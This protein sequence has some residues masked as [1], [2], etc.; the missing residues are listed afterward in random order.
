M[1]S[2]R[3]SMALC[4]L[5]AGAFGVRAV[6]ATEWARFA[7]VSPTAP[8][9]AGHLCYTDGLGIACDA[10]APLASGLGLSDR[11]TS[12][13]SSVFVAQDSAVSVTIGGSN[14]A[15]FGTGGLGITAINASGLIK[16]AG[17]STTGPI[18]GTVGY[19]AGNMGIGTSVPS[20]TLHVQGTGL[21]IQA[22]AQPSNYKAIIEEVSNGNNAF[23]MTHNQSQFFG[24]DWTGGISFFYPST[25]TGRLGILTQ[26]PAATLQVS[27]T[28]IVSTTY[29]N[30]TPSLYVNSAGNVGIGTSTPGR[31]LDV[32]GGIK[33]RGWGSSTAGAVLFGAGEK[34][35]I[36]GDDSSLMAFYTNALERIRINPSGNVG[37]STT[38]PSAKLEVVGSTSSTSVEA[39][40]VTTA[41]IKLTSATTASA[42][43]TTDADVGAIRLNG[44]RAEICS[45]YPN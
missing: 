10:S 4:I 6:G 21:T 19:F 36:Y 3:V 32:Y 13:T 18:S 34:A 17:V 38:N 33:S 1:R 7:I 42:Q 11:I 30:T 43:C 29:Q 22:T 37:I 35:S 8:M 24:T 25:P 15:N 20:T 9:S 26:Y 23:R 14:V 41:G 27:G 5:L 45:P 40:S 44:T 12:G 31:T 39:V 2:L 16:A 28:F